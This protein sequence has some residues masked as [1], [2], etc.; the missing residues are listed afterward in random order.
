MIK[1][2][3]ERLFAGRA[4]PR[5]WCHADQAFAYLPA[6]STVRGLPETRAEAH[7]YQQVLDVPFLL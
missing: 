3:R 7:A 2:N 4:V 1:S 5:Q 6:R